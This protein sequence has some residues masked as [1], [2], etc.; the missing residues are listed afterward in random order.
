MIDSVEK[1]FL[2][3]VW[4]IEASYLLQHYAERETCKEHLASVDKCDP[5]L[6]GWLLLLNSKQNAK[7]S[8][9]QDENQLIFVFLSG[10]FQNL[11]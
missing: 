10:R 3:Y 2:S 11:F 7:F 1:P 9:F 4:K 8:D 6:K 5:T